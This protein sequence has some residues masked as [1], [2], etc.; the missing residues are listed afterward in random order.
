METSI[1]PLLEKP[2]QRRRHVRKIIITVIFLGL[3]LWLILPVVVGFS[4]VRKF[5]D[6]AQIN[7][8]FSD[9]KFKVR[10]LAAKSQPNF[11]EERIRVQCSKDMRG[12]GISVYDL[13]EAKIFET[14][15]PAGE[16]IYHEGHPQKIGQITPVR[17][18]GKPTTCEM[19]FRVSTTATNTIWHGEQAGGTVDTSLPTPMIVSEIKTNWP[20][21]YERGTILPLANLGP[22]K[23]LL[24]LK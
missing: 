14:S 9:D 19:L 5:F 12:V 22:Y 21:T 16:I 20:D 2:S 15:T 17:S 3:T 11:F 10:V 1:P 18:N 7:I 24:F 23:I 8:V 4:I 13:K 6:D